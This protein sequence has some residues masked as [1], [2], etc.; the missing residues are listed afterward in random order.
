MSIMKSLDRW[1][2]YFRSCSSSSDIFEIID[3]AIMVA[4]SDFFK[5]FRLR[6]D[7]I[8]EMLFSCKQTRCVDCDRV[9]LSVP[10]DDVMVLM[11][12][13]LVVVFEAGTS[14]GSKVNSSRDDIDDHGD[15]DVN[16]VLSNYNFDEVEALTDEMED[17]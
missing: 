11:M 8:V 4:T 16:R 10:G 6:R 7:C 17:Q 12:V 3:H 14:K 2:S 15:M 13:V 9:E 1:R 5:E